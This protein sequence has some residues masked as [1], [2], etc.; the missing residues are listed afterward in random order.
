MIGM[1]VATLP[2]R[3]E[4]DS[5]WSFDELVKHVREKCLA[6][7]EHS[8]YPLQHI[9]ADFHHEQSNVSFLEIVFDFITVSSNIDQLS[10]DGASLEQKSL[11]ESSEVA[12][13]NFML[14]FF[15]N[16]ASTDAKLACRF[17]CSRDLFEHATVGRIAQRFQHLFSQL[18]SSNSSV[19]QGYQCTKPISKL[20]LI[21][22]EETEEMQGVVFH[23]LMDLGTEGMFISFGY[24]LDEY[25]FCEYGTLEEYE[26]VE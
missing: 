13:F 24:I 3:V 15:Y 23:R 7:L 17:V 14:T 16:P 26:K 10:F 21:L 1:F 12:K 22:P 6:I 2:Y 11:D 8:H 4:V 25:H 5:H 20:S 9:L 18:F 19:T